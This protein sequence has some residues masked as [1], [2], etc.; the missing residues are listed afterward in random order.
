[1]EGR[2]SE[3]HELEAWFVTGSQ[4]LYGEGALRQVADDSA[5]ICASLHGS[6]HAPLHIVAKPT[7][8]TPEG[9]AALLLE[10]DA[11]PNCVGVIAWM[12]TFSPAKMWT[13]GLKALGK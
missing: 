9:I 13:T 6:S 1:G 12:H 3:L 5:T 8:T 4:S 11:A 7:V 2:M 10:A